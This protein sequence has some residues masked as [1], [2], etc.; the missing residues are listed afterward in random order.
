MSFFSSGTPHFELNLDFGQ[1]KK[2]PKKGMVGEKFI[3]LNGRNP[4]DIK[5][6][7]K[8]NDNQFRL[9][10]SFYLKAQKNINKKLIFLF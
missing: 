5:E 6:H 4:R 9:C 10:P 3:S 7:L 8:S 1:N 2:D